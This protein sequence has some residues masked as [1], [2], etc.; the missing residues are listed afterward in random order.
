[1][2]KKRK[3]GNKRKF[4]LYA[5][6]IHSFFWCL[7]CV[8]TVLYHIYLSFYCVFL[9][10]T[11]CVNIVTNRVSAFIFCTDIWKKFMRI[12][13]DRSF[14]PASFFVSHVK[15]P[16]ITWK[17]FSFTE[18]LSK[19]LRKLTLGTKLWPWESK[20][21]DIGINKKKKTL[22]SALKYASH[23]YFSYIKTWYAKQ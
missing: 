5:N 14:F 8:Y 1:M 7:R 9:K 11:Y 13:G 21:F 15:T 6:I 20:Q 10:K 18:F 17:Y 22:F 12:N 19:N 2:W 23:T 4:H 3:M 16:C